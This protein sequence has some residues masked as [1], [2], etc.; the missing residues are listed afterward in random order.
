[1]LRPAL[2]G[3]TWLKLGG[4]YDGM[5][6]RSRMPEL[7]A[8]RGIAALAVL[9]FHLL[10]WDSHAPGRLAAGLRAVFRPGWLGV[11]LF[12]VLSGFLITG[13]LLDTKGKAPTSSFLDFYTRRTF[14]ILPVYYGS[15]ALTVLAALTMGAHIHWPG[16]AL[17]G[18]F[19]ANLGVES[20]VGFGG[21]WSLAVEEHFY[22]VGRASYVLAR[23]VFLR[24]YVRSSSWLSRS[25]G[26]HW[27]MAAR[28]TL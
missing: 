5:Q 7:D 25:S 11:D 27:G 22:L 18:V 19:L 10:S 8:V 17:A 23:R 6:A 3:L 26:T 14:R 9:E 1:M 24:W 21:Y 20:T 13:I 12:F 15:A 28:F 2:F 16:I 4:Q